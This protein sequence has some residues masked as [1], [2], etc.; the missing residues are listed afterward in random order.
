M[1]YRDFPSSHSSIVSAVED[2]ALIPAPACKVR[3]VITL[4]NA[5]SIASIEIHRQLC[6]VY[7]H[8]HGS[9]VN[10]FLTG[11]RLGGINRQPPY[12]PDL[13][14]SDF[15]FSYTSRNSCPVSQRYQNDREEADFYD[16]G[17]SFWSHGVTNV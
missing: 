15:Y 1:H 8:T 7:G 13:A 17:Y 12:S 16:T 5:E 6:Q 2:E 9:K 3:S 11:V 14:P 10:I 4:L